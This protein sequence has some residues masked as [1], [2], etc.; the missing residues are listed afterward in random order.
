MI[1]LYINLFNCVESQRAKEFDYVL[2]KNL[3][4]KWIDEVVIFIS[5]LDVFI[6]PESSKIKTVI[7]D[8][9]Y[10]PT[11]SDFVDEANK[12]ITCKNDITI[13]ANSDCYFDDSIQELLKYDLR[14]HCVALSRWEEKLDGYINLECPVNSQ[15][16]WM[17]QGRIRPISNCDYSLGIYGCDNRFAWQCTRAGYLN[18]NPCHTIIMRHYHFSS[19]R[20]SGITING[21]KET[22]MQVPID[23][24]NLPPKNSLT[25]GIFSYSLFGSE[26]RYLAGA[27]M[28]AALVKYVYPGFWCRYYVDSS[29]S[30]ELKQE[31]FD[32]GVEIVE[33]KPAMNLAGMFWRFE[34]L[35]FAGVDM[36]GVRDIDSRLSIRDREVTME[37]LQSNANYHTF[38]DHPYHQ[39]HINGGFFSAK[40]PISNISELISKYQHNGYYGQDENFLR[41]IIWPEIKD[42]LM[43]HSTFN[44]GPEG[45][46]KGNYLNPSFMQYR[47]C[48]ERVYHDEHVGHTD[49]SVFGYQPCNSTYS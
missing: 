38:R 34:A 36:V 41:D 8:N 12:R 27:K 30:K 23:T 13:I 24:C 35:D 37:W 6:L 26:N 4:N 7:T 48:V 20:N 43:I 49:H 47:F 15:D 22:V 42:E 9:L 11:Y 3:E 31:L 44:T 45:A 10:R 17:F 39:T 19:Y 1:R 18:I 32:M 16:A 40:K 28:N 14:Y 33:K 25:T 21:P 29:I 2:K 46:Y 5:K